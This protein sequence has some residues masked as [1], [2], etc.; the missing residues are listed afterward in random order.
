MFIIFQGPKNEKSQERKVE[1]K[2]N[3]KKS[4][5]HS[6]IHGG[7]VRFGVNVVAGENEIIPFPCVAAPSSSSQKRK[8][9]PTTV[10]VISA[11]LS[12]LLG[13]LVFLALPALFFQNVEEWSFLESLYFVVI[14]LTTVGFGDYVPGTGPRGSRNRSVKVLR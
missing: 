14:T 8:V 1:R 2:V 6:H 11:V 4:E 7:N 9:K 13:C 12:I 3:K 5:I 10:R